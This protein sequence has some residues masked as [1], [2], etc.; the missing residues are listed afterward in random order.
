MGDQGRRLPLLLVLTV[1]MNLSFRLENS[2]MRFRAS[3]LVI[4][5]RRGRSIVASLV[6]FAFLITFPCEVTFYVSGRHV[7]IVNFAN[8]THESNL[9]ER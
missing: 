3:F 4:T 2:F 7:N 5:A 8:V 9:R 1:A 6:D